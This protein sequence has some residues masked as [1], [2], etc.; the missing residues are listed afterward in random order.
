[1][2][3]RW[4]Q[5]VRRL[6]ALSLRE[7]VIMTASI[8]AALLAAVDAWILSPQYATQRRML[9]GLQ[10]QG[11]E[12]QALRARLVAPPADTPNARLTA[13]LTEQ[14]AEMQ[15]VEQAIE[16]RLAGQTPAT[17]PALLRNVLRR[18]ERLTLLKLETVAAAPAPEGAAV[19]ARRLVLIQLS[20]R[21]A[22]LSAYAGAIE[23]QLPGL[24]WHDLTLDA[25]MQP[26]VLSAQLWLTGGGS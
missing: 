6:E 18:H 7:R 21:Y 16:T 2:K 26:P 9:D 17:L 22:D 11:A 24:R 12:L 23:Q 10:R 19:P 8:A 5:L 1:M 15:R 13:A 25:S 3:Q 14:Q 4:K 20:G